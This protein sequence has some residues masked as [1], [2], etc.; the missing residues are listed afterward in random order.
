M[1]R[2]TGPT[3]VAVLTKMRKT[4]GC[5]LTAKEWAAMQATNISEL[6]AAEQQ[7][8]LQGTDLWYQSGFTWA[9]VAMAQVIRSRLSAKR[10]GSYAVL[11]SRTRLCSESPT[12]FQND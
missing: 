4:G 5:K 8:R 3:L 10:A 11:H 6:S 1:K 12:Q 9:I 2:L 7:R